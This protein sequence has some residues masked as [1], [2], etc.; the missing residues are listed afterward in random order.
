MNQ[1]SQIVKMPTTTR[2]GSRRSGAAADEFAIVAPLLI[3]LILGI[4]A[5]GQM[6]MVQQILAR[7]RHTLYLVLADNLPSKMHFPE[8]SHVR[9]RR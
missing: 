4:I 9:C 3:L 1:S 2:S 6:V 7:V 8:L 5:F